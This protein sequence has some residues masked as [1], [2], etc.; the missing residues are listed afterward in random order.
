MIDLG[1]GAIVLNADELRQWLV[2]IRANDHQDPCRKAV[3][4]AEQNGGA[5]DK[6]V[7]II[8]G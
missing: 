7:N 3:Q 8:T 6:I 1:I 4:Y 5:T 2:G